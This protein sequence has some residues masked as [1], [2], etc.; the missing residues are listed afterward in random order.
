M[1]IKDIVSEAVSDIVKTSPKTQSAL[2]NLRSFK[3]TYDQNRADPFGMRQSTD[4]DSTSDINDKTGMVPRDIISQLNKLD[5]NEKRKLLKI[6]KG[7]II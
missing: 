4:Q 1:K 5:E 2:N 6:L 3:S 7:K